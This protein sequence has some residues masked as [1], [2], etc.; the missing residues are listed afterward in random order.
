MSDNSE[1]IEFWNGEMATTWISV[2]DELDK[3]LAPLTNIAMDAVTI[4]EGDRAIDIGCGCGQTTFRLAE[5]G[6]SVWGVDIS[7]PMVADAH[8]KVGALENIAFSVS[9]AAV[10]DYTPDHQL[11]FSRFGVMFFADPIGAF[12]NIRTALAED[13]SLLFLCWQSPINNPWMSVAGAAVQPFLP[14]VPPPD[15]RAPG[16]F[17]FADAD[18]LREILEGAGYSDVKIESVTADVT[19]GLDLDDTIR[20]QSFVGPLSAVMKEVDE[21]TREG[22]VIPAVKEAL[23][24]YVTDEGVK[25]GAATWLVSAR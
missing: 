6:A 19:L 17:A 21:E 2:Q 18:Y 1:Q 25:L 12:T 3:L 7:K 14:A 23:A 8:S 11:V 20:F 10:Q 15:P 4:G 24:P 13:G 5:T 22:K 9:D 16:P